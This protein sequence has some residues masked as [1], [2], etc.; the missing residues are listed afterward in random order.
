MFIILIFLQNH[1][2]H[3]KAPRIE[4]NDGNSMPTLGLGTSV[5]CIVLNIFF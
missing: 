1:H 5:V 4:L 2:F 3:G